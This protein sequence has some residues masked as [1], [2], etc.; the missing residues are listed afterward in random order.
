MP[1]FA[2]MDKSTGTHLHTAFAS[3]QAA[4]ESII[5]NHLDK[6]EVSEVSDLISQYSVVYGNGQIVHFDSDK[7]KDFLS[8]DP[9]N[10]SRLTT[11]QRQQL[12]QAYISWCLSNQ[13]NV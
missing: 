10:S 11:E 5:Y 4:E 9:D 1:L 6:Y 3:K 7:F 12:G 2:I 8:R 13:N